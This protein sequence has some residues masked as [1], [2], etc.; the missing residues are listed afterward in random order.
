M[1]EKSTTPDPG[2]VRTPER[3]MFSFVDGMIVRAAGRAALAAAERLGEQRG[4][5]WSG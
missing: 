1:S 5:A 2:D 3:W 4:L